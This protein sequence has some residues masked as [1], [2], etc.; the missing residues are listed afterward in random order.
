[1]IAAMRLHERYLHF[2]TI[3]ME[4]PDIRSCC[5]LCGQEFCAVPKQHERVDDVLLRIREE[6]NAHEC[7]IAE[8]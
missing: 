7:K 6:Y 4:Q 3:D 1:M 2:D 5:S 8:R